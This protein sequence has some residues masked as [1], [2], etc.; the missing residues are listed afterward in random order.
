MMCAA[1]R[2]PEAVPLRS[3]NPVPALIRFF[4]TFGLPQRIQSDQGTNFMSKIFTQVMSELNVKYN[5]SSAYHP[6]SQGALERFHQTLKSMLRKFCTKS[7]RDWDDG[8]PLLLFAVR[9]TVQESLG[10]APADLVFGHS[11]RGPLCV[12]HEKWLSDKPSL[13]ENIL[14][15]VSSLKERLR[16]TCELACT[17]L[18]TAQT[19]MKLNY[20]KKLK[21]SFRVH[22]WWIVSSVKLISG[23]TLPVVRKKNV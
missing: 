2:Y 8:L 11:I 16:H 4:S 22:M 12:L 1:T 23:T 14:D 3:L 18:S 15:F 10:F 7:N 19:K 21:K 13:K 17:S 9:E 5:V 6:E 20:N